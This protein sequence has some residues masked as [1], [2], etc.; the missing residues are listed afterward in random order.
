MAPPKKG[1]PEYTA[2]YVTHKERF[3]ELFVAQLKKAELYPGNIDQSDF[4]YLRGYAAGKTQFYSSPN[5]P[6][7]FTDL[8]LQG[9][10]DGKGELAL[11]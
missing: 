2:K 10:E 3:M 11:P 1:T 5:I 4:W 8:Y 6:P 9:L 7:Q